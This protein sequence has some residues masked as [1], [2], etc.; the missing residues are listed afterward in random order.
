M[1]EFANTCLMIGRKIRVL[2]GLQGC[3]SAVSFDNYQQPIT[4]YNDGDLVG[5]EPDLR[6]SLDQVQ[7]FF[8]GEKVLDDVR[9]RHPIW[10]VEPNIPGV[11]MEVVDNINHNL[12]PRGHINHQG[13]LP[14]P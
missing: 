13:P 1:S 9:L 2:N 6:N 4:L 5:Q 12:I 11:E 14:T 10:N 3:D 7:G 8:V